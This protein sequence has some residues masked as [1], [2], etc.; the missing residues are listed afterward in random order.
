[1]PKS[2]VTSAIELLERK[3]I[4]Y[5]ELERICDQFFVFKRQ[6]ASSHRIY[7]TAFPEELVNIQPAKNGDAKGYQLKQVLKLL[8]RMLG[9]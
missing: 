7:M 5:K 3:M 4:S 9:E 2:D 1:M 8:R 6:N